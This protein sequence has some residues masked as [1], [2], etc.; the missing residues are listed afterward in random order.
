MDCFEGGRGRGRGSMS[1]HMHMQKEQGG[2]GGPE[3]EGQA[4]SLLNMEPFV[5]L[6]LDLTTLR[7]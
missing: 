6:D 7:S 1:M 3:G 2:T 4:G 5:G